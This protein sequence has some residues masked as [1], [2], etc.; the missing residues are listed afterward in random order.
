M[1]KRALLT[2][3]ALL[4]LALTEGARAVA[5]PQKKPALNDQ[6]R[7]GRE[8]Y[9]K[10][11][12]PSGEDV[13]A[14]VGE[15]EVTASTLK[16]ADC[17]GLR[18]EGKTEGGVA[19]GALTWKHLTGEDGHTHPTGRRHGPF[20][21]STFARAV[22]YGLDPEENELHVT[23]PRYGLPK[24]DLTDLIAY[25]KRIGEEPATGGAPPAAPEP[26]TA[27]RGR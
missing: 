16:C 8:L 3:V 25:L 15:L 5:P 24:K 19:A 14:R 6:E 9:E 26:K 7:R 27:G 23:M 4:S 2:A 11:V 20:D 18:G 12:S 21:E 22:A 10:G 1:T 17:H 13:V